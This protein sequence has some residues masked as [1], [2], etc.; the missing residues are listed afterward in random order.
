MS[1]VSLLCPHQPSGSGVVRRYA[2]AVREGGYARLWTG[3]SFQIESHMALAGLGGTE[4]AVPVGIGTALAPLRTPYDAALQAR[5]LAAV[6]G[7]PVSVA[8]GASDPDFV[9]ATRGAPL[10]RP[11]SYTAA[12]AGI[13]RDLLAGRSVTSTEPGLEA[14]EAR[15]PAFETGPVEVGTGVLRPGMASRSRDL[16]DFVVTW[17]TPRTYVRDVL[18]PRLTRADGTRARVVTNV[19]V[20]LAGPGRSPNLLA[21]AGCSNHLARFHYSDMLRRAGIDAH[22]SDIASGARELVR[23]NVFVVGDAQEVA[24]QIRDIGAHGI[25][26]VVVNPT[27]VAT[28]HGDEAALD[29][30]QQISEALRPKVMS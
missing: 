8:Y 14:R 9:T 16:V 19:H 12:Y 29:D 20:A 15:L 30:L 24:E 22:P 5:S 6:L 2:R 1:E 28:V 11:A 23:R 18:L 3:Q 26:E 4:D 21:Q 13:V 25:D 17:M 10:E 7:R 27:A